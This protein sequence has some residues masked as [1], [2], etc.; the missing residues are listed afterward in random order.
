MTLKHKR[1]TGSQYSNTEVLCIVLYS[2]L[3]VYSKKMLCSRTETFMCTFI[4]LFV[5]YLEFLY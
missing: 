4:K 5:Y 3:L 2:M 1:G